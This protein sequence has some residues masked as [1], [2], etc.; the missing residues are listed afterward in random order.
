MRIAPLYFEVRINRT[1]TAFSIVV[2]HLCYELYT[3]VWFFV[4]QFFLLIHLDFLL[5]FGL[6]LSAILTPQTATER[7]FFLLSFCFQELLQLV[8]FY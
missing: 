7:I 2:R 4:L 3:R 8:S 1:P 6:W 5:W